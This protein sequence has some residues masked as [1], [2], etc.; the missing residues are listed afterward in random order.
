MFIGEIPVIQLNL[1]SLAYDINVER[2]LVEASVKEV[3]NTLSRSIEKLCSCEFAFT[4]IG[5]LV[6]SKGSAKMKF[7]PSFLE[8]MDSTG[9]LTRYLIQVQCLIIYVC[10]M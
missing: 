4:T 6:I 3:I 10:V 2:D 8:K 7:L 9:G 5:N 1:T